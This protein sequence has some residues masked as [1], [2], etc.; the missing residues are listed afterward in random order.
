VF[1]QSGDPVQAGTVASLA[2]PGGNI[3]GFLIF[4][5]SMSTKFLQLL[6]DIAPRM[7][8]VGV[9]QSKA[10]QRRVEAT[11]LWKSSKLLARSG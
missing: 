6:K 4:E 9:L 7:T 11:I 5:P 2:R 8:R 1:S 10:T 3:T